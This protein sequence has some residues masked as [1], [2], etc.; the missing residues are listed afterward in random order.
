MAAA[1]DIG[2]IVVDDP[3]EGFVSISDY[4]PSGTNTKASDNYFTEVRSINTILATARIDMI[5]ADQL[6]SNIMRSAS[7]R[8]Y[9]N[10]LKAKDRLMTILN[11]AIQPGGSGTDIDGKTV[12]PY[13]DA[14]QAYQ[15]NLIQMTGGKSVLVPDSLKMSLGWEKELYT[16]T[17]F[18]QPISIAQIKNDERNDTCYAAYVNVPFNFKSPPY[19][20]GP[21]YN[22]VFYAID[23]NIRLVDY[24]GFLPSSENGNLPYLIPSIIKVEA[25]QQFTDRN[26]STDQLQTRTV[27]S[28]ACA[29][30][31]SLGERLPAAGALGVDF[32]TGN[33]PGLG[34]LLDIFQTPQI[35]KSPTDLLYT[36]P[37][38]D[39]PPADFI[40]V[41]P[42]P[43]PS[44]HPPFANVLALGM[45]D[46]IRRCGTGVNV[47]SLI[48][49]FVLPFAWSGLSTDP[50]AEYYQMDLQ[51]N[52]NHFAEAT[53]KKVTRPVTQ[54]QI[55]AR[56]GITLI[57]VD[58]AGNKTLYDVF[59]KDYVNQPGRTMGGV[60]AGESMGDAMPPCINKLYGIG[61]EIDEL[62]FAGTF[63]TGPGNGA[64]RPTYQQEDAVAV[65]I[66]VRGRSIIVPN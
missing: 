31:A 27:H 62:A 52:I 12:S 43:L 28:I 26:P 4:P 45:Y 24:R 21:A 38:G 10:A 66:L 18:P 35:M 32:P 36:P 51:G 64:V 55:Y 46:W 11:A 39:S 14:V 37:L 22:F 8:D 16:T 33:A 44:K 15:S 58:L 1:K 30:P 20:P 34:H 61:R 56:S 47:K 49:A 59:I 48:D 60:H 25:D 29:E 5:I 42:T 41:V 19:G 3:D 2:R 53:A 17:V 65:D 40:E 7:I 23:S 6:N 50:H 63:P 54:H 13:D 57:G 9:Q